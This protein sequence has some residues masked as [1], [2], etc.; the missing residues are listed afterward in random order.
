MIPLLFEKAYTSEFDAVVSVACSARSQRSR[1][2]A[3]SW[4]EEHLERRINSQ[5]SAARKMDA[6]KYVVWTEG[7][8]DTHRRQWLRILS[9]MGFLD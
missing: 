8:M 6:S 5:W 3:R 2:L 4:S 1:L 7:S 9:E